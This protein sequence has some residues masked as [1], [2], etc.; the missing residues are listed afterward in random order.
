MVC[1]FPKAVSTRGK[2]ISNLPKRVITRSTGK[3]KI[4]SGFY[5]MFSRGIAQLPGFS[6]IWRHAGASPVH[7][8]GS[9]ALRGS[10]AYVTTLLASVGRCSRPERIHQEI[11]CF[12]TTLLASVERCSPR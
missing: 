12:A 4:R 3:I 2:A 1:S 10:L 8:A 6:G 11:R 5:R 9:A 7:S